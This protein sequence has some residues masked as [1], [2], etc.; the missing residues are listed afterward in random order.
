MRTIDVEER[1]VRL[2]RRHRL[3]TGE[4]ARDVV[5]AARSV[6]ALHATDPASVY[7]S[8]QA[9]LAEMTVA[10]LDRA[11]YR[12]RSLVKHLAMRRTLFVFPRD[13]MGDA[14]AG[15]SKRVEGA[16]RRRL[17]RLVESEGLRTRGEAW[18]AEASREVLAALSGGREASSTE[19]RREIPLLE[20]SVA[21]GEGKSWG[22]NVPIGPRVL[23]VLSAAGKI[24][25]ASN[26]GSWFTSRP[27]WAR[28][29]DWLGEEVAAPP[30]PEGVAG[31]V[32]RWLRAFGPGT[33]ADLKWWLGSTV[34]A[35]RRA[36]A[37]VG[38]AEVELGGG[39]GYVLPDD[40]EPPEPVEPWAALL[41][42]LDPTTMGWYERDWYLGA[43]RQQLFDSAG[44]AGPTIWWDGRIVGGWRQDGAGDVVVQMLEDV[45]GDALRAIEDEAARLTEWL[46]GTRVLP[47]FPS[48]LFRAA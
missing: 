11:L 45:G 29:E 26:D 22:G 5:E 17:V 8:A 47:R 35:V 16:E 38:A 18:L 7:L 28:M 30:E 46:G 10:D 33:A 20:G 42:P 36:L 44:N 43:H 24:V 32:E 1:R 40:L 31:L 3:A 14:Q 25:R 4:R 37:D 9:R 27:R 12:D 41:P 23:T 34:T 19:L 13:T 2:A 6:V 48:P 39:N 15:A 21:Y